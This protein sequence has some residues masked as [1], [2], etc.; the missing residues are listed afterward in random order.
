MMSFYSLLGVVAATTGAALSAVMTSAWVNLAFAVLFAYLGLSMLGLY[1]VQVLPALTAKLDTAAT[2]WGGFSGTF[3]MGITAGLV[4]SPCV[5][6]VAGSILLEITGQ[7]VAQGSGT[8]SGV[9]LSVLG[10]GIVLMTGFGLGL[11]FVFLVVGL[12]SHRLPQSGTW[13]LRVKVLLGLAIFL[14][15]IPRRD[16]SSGRDRTTEPSTP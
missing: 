1:E 8:G 7:A 16:N 3:L 2:R 11:S 6:P 10:R 4:V 9:A 13:L 14:R 12:L 15:S 5:G